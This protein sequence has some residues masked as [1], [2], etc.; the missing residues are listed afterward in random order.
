M[1]NRSARGTRCRWIPLRWRNRAQIVAAKKVLRSAGMGVALAAVQGLLGVRCGLGLVRVAL[2]W[3]LLGVVQWFVLGCVVL[4]PVLLW[5]CSCC[6]VLV[7]VGRGLPCVWS[8]AVSAVLAC[9]VCCISRLCWVVSLMFWGFCVF[10]GFRI[11]RVS[12]SSKL[13]HALMSPRSEIVLCL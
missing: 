7:S 5:R 11:F 6:G 1:V 9:G 13:L 8:L 3:R 2:R 12:W 10:L 4:V